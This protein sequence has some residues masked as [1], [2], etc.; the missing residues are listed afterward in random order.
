MMDHNSDI[1]LLQYSHPVVFWFHL[2]PPCS[3]MFGQLLTQAVTL[4]SSPVSSLVWLTK[5]SLVNGLFAQDAEKSSLRSFKGSLLCIHWCVW[6]P[7]CATEKEADKH[8]RDGHNQCFKNSWETESLLFMRAEGGENWRPI[9]L[10][11]IGATP[12][13]FA[14]LWE[15]QFK[16][17]WAVKLSNT[18]HNLE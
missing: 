14:P 6:W 1:H 15:N 10:V 16:S 18:L 9:I 3:G 17:G 2:V 11:E 8:Q 5:D 4:E 7:L 13:H 12:R